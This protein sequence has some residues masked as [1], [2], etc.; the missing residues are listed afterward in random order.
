MRGILRDLDLEGR[1]LAPDEELELRY[2]TAQAQYEHS[3][4]P[5]RRASLFSQNLGSGAKDNE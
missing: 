3:T 4:V 5:E 2:R 1:S